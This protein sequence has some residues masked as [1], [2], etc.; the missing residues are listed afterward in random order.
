MVLFW[1]LALLVLAGLVV[2]GGQQVT[3]TRRAEAVAAGAA[4]AATDA[5][6]PA[7]V[8]GRTD[9]GAALSAAN[10]YLAAS[11]PV[12]GTAELEGTAVRVRTSQR[13][14][15]IFLA[16]L[17]IGEVRGSATARAELVRA[18]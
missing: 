10:R 15:T 5:A 3:A 14:P 11:G 4:R 6:A 13:A 16:L 8:A 18:D 2:D 17:G 12:S 1:V 9:P 7:R